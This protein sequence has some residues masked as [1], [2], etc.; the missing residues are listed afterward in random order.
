LVVSF[1][2]GVT[3]GHF[4]DQNYG[5]NKER[6]RIMEQTLGEEIQPKT[7][8]Q[9]TG[10]Y[11][12]GGLDGAVMGAIVAPHS[13]AFIPVASLNTVAFIAGSYIGKG[14][15]KFQRHRI[16]LSSEEQ[17]R[18]NKYLSEIKTRGSEEDAIS[19]W[20]DIERNSIVKDLANKKNPHLVIDFLEKY[21]QAK[22]H[23]EFYHLVNSMLEHRDRVNVEGGFAKHAYIIE[24]DA[25]SKEFM[26]Y[27]IQGEELIEV[28]YREGEEVL[29]NLGLNHPF[30][31]MI[32]SIKNPVEVSTEIANWDGSKE[33]LVE[34]LL[35]NYIEKNLAIVSVPK[36]ASL[37]ATFAQIYGM[38]STQMHAN[39]E[40][41]KK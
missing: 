2:G 14:I 4:Q 7:E 23:G 26:A 41:E 28:K 5:V 37:T 38:Y 17:E 19:G 35:A 11:L 24:K 40:L 27:I 34:K 6:A 21:K 15:S 31:R 8:L 33:G 3:Y 32:F 29:D 16:K 20:Y 10:S 22:Q 9:L 36:D 30:M 13:D 12:L 39:E 18:V 1:A 25:N